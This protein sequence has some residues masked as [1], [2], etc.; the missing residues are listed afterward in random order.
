MR[1]KWQLKKRMN[2]HPFG[3]DGCNPCGCDNYRSF[4]TFRFDAVEK[5]GF[6]RASLTG[7]ENIFI[8]MLYVIECEFE[9]RVCSE[10]HVNECMFN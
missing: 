1:A 4:E 5:G 9:F 7:Q 3:I 8:G 6:A 2:R 10:G